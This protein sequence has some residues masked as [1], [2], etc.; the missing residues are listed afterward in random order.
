MGLR[1][2]MLFQKFVLEQRGNDLRKI[3]FFYGSFETRKC[4]VQFGEVVDAFTRYVVRKV[5]SS[6]WI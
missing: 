2:F 1:F 4:G 6:A 5:S 3:I